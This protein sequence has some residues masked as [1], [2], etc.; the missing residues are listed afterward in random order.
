MEVKVVGGE[1]S[2][3]EID[4][5]VN[6]VKD[7]CG[8]STLKSLEIKVDGE[9]VELRWSTQPQ[10]FNRIR[11]VTGYLSGDITT[12]NNAKLAEEKDRVKHI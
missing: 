9:Y 8:R 5:Y 12:W 2:K 3:E 4:V 6:H 7:K 1:L 11:R 10:K